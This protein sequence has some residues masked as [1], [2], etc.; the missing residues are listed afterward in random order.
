MASRDYAE[1]QVQDQKGGNRVRSSP[2]LSL[3]GG[4]PSPVRV[5]RGRKIGHIK[6]GGTTSLRVPLRRSV[7]EEADHLG[8]GVGTG[9][10]GVRA[11]RLTPGPGMPGALDQPELRCGGTVGASAIVRV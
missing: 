10:I 7:Q 1:C 2:R 5:D 9:R 6:A 3:S 11:G 4:C 8:R